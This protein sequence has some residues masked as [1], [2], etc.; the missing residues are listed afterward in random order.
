MKREVDLSHKRTQLKFDG[1]G[2][3]FKV[4][5]IRVSLSNAT[6]SRGDFASGMVVDMMEMI[7]STEVWP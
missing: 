2:D 4:G 6:K 1:W 7:E 5:V 3:G